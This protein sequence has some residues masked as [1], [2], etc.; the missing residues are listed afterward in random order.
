MTDDGTGGLQ[1]RVV[2]LERKFDHV[3]AIVNRVAQGVIGCR[4]GEAEV[5][6]LFC[7]HVQSPEDLT[8]GIVHEK[9]CLTLRAR[10]AVQKLPPVPERLSSSG[11]AR[12]GESITPGGDHG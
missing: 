5:R 8:A 1:E 7:L 10:Q 3:R 12:A 11:A 9:T 6:C 4:I 2:D